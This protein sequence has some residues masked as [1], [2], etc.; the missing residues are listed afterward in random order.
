MMTPATIQL[1]HLVFDESP[2]IP[3]VLFDQDGLSWILDSG[4]GPLL[5]HLLERYPERIPPGHAEY[6]KAANLSA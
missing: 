3:P 2:R 5:W 6:V 4:L 1:I